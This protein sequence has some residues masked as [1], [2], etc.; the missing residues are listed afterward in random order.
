MNKT[1]KAAAIHQFGG[2]D[3]FEIIDVAIPEID[4]NEI[5]IRLDFAGLG[6][7]DVFEREGGYAQMLGLVANFPYILGSEGAGTVARIGAAVKG[8][9][10]GDAVYAS[11][12]LNPKG[13]FYAQYAAVSA[14]LVNHRPEHLS[15]RRLRAIRCLTT[16]PIPMPTLCVVWQAFLKADLFIPSSRRFIH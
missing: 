4:D 12:F 7:W 5:L 1:M 11:G 9:K 16:M 6:S 13:G 2:I 15:R 8:F 10:E 3:R 14:D